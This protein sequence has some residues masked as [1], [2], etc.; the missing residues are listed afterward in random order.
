MTTHQVDREELLLVWEKRLDDAHRRF[1]STGI[2]EAKVEY[3]KV[4]RVFAAL[5]RGECPPQANLEDQP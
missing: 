2:A 4:L 3:L 5:A 1:Q